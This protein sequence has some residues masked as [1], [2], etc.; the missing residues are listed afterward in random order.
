MY[1]SV[2]RVEKLSN[3]GRDS[4]RRRMLFRQSDSGADD[5]AASPS[6]SPMDDLSGV[7][8]GELVADNESGDAPRLLRMT[9]LRHSFIERRISPMHSDAQDRSST[10]QTS[11]YDQ[12][13]NCNN[14]GQGDMSLFILLHAVVRR[15]CM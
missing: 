1:D 8:K 11:S 14:K 9:P 12:D 6:P 3:C 13:N 5:Y 15:G 4:G 7:G 10:L 2:N